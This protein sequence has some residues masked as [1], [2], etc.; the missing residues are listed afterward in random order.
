[1]YL[2]FSIEATSFCRPTP[3]WAEGQHRCITFTVKEVK[4]FILLHIK[5][6]FVKRE[7]KKVENL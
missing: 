5:G 6:C 1:M 7:G 3:S 2:L 4:K